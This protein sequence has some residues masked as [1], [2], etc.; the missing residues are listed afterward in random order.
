MDPP[1][2]RTPLVEKKL[3]RSVSQPLEIVDI[4]SAR[5]RSLDN[6]SGG[7]GSRGVGKPDSFKRTHIRR[8]SEPLLSRTQ[9]QSIPLKEMGGMGTLLEEPVGEGEE[10]DR[11][12]AET[13]LMEKLLKPVSVPEGVEPSNEFFPMGYRM[14]TVY[15]DGWL[16][17][18]CG[19]DLT[20][21]INYRG[22]NSD[23]TQF[24]DGRE[25]EEEKRLTPSEIHFNVE[26]SAVLLR[27]F[28]SLAKDLLAL[29]VS[30][31]HFHHE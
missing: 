22:H 29:R 8:G 1:N 24:E 4:Q 18:G 2:D 20:I 16:E 19:P 5:G 25:G 23:P 27:V 28:G 31:I 9:I 17:I 7:S 14:E 13:E 3:M 10:G 15:E 12:T 30:L 6:S 21:E 11:Q 26:A